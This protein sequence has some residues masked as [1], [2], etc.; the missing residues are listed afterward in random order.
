MLH[1]DFKCPK[2]VRC[3]GSPYHTHEI[4]SSL[5]TS[6]SAN[7]S[8]SSRRWKPTQNWKRRFCSWGFCACNSCSLYHFTP[9]RLGRMRQTLDRGIC[10]S[11]LPQRVDFWGLLTKVSHTCL[12]VS[13][14]GPGQ[15]FR[16]AAHR[17]PFCWNFL[18]HSRT[19]LFV[20]G[21]VWYLVRNFRCTSQ[22]TQFWQ[23]PRHR[24]LSYPLSTL[25]FITTAPQWWN[26]Q[27]CHGAYYFQ[28]P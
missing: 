10:D 18:Y 17:Q 8:S 9:R 28:K 19:V 15:P 12:T 26:V 21:S 27:V 23:I 20:G 3:D 25:C 13:A 5:K 7:P 24:T 6:F 22:L 16:F 11:W 14:D 1:E 4:A 2:C